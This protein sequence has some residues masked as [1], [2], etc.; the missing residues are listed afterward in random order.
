MANAKIIT[1]DFRRVTKTLV[2][3]NIRLTFDQVADSIGVLEIVNPL[4]RAEAGLTEKQFTDF[5]Q[6]IRD[7]TGWEI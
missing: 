1:A 7:L 3:G 6:Q 4:Q 2:K 5:V